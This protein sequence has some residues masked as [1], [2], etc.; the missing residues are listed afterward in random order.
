MNNAGLEEFTDQ[1]F[2]VLDTD[3]TK[4][5]NHIMT[6]NS[7]LITKLLHKNMMHRSKLSCLRDGTHE[8]KVTKRDVYVCV[9]VC[10]CACV[11]LWKVA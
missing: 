8:Y 3:A 1:F 5:Q 9:C 7:S 4:K 11:H 10:V 6:I 2:K